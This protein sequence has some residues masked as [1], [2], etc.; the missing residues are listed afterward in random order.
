MKKIFLVLIISILC[1]PLF[2]F[3]E[4]S[5]IFTNQDLE[6]YGEDTVEDINKSDESPPKKAETLGDIQ[7]EMAFR[8]QLISFNYQIGLAKDLGRFN[9]QVLYEQK[10][11]E[12]KVKVIET[13]GSLPG[14]WKEE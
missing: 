8:E 4:G 9:T 14:W 13:Y 5:K 1:F 12:L 2:A 10:R 6:Q 3:P 7:K 11:A